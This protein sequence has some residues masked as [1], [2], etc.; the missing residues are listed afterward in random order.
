MDKVVEIGILFDYY[1]KLLTD[2]Q[3]EIVDQYY[4]EDLS[5]SEI[6]EI[7]G[8]SKQAVSE[9]LKRAEKKLYNYEKKLLLVDRNQKISKGIQNALEEMKRLLSTEDEYLSKRELE[10]LMKLFE[11][12]EKERLEA[13]GY[14]I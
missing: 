9:N 11:E 3:F 6:A 14:D 2:K 4:N 13:I 1:G 12:Y 7:H 10:D 8:I 5:L